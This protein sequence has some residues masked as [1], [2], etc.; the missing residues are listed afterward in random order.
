MTSGNRDER[1]GSR[2]RMTAP[3]LGDAWVPGQVRLSNKGCWT[4]AVAPTSRPD[5]IMILRPHSLTRLQVSRAVPP[6]DWW[7]V[8]ADPEGW[9]EISPRVLSEAAGR[10]TCDE[11]TGEPDPPS[12][13]D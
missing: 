8:P 3:R 6:P 9:S 2:V 1:D 5:T 7:A 11:V 13:G 10:S 12:P 4:V